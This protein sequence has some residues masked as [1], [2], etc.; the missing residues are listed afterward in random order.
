MAKIYVA[1]S[2]RNEHQQEVVKVLRELRHEVYDFKNPE[3]KTGFQWSEIDKDWQNW[4]T[5]Q[6]REALEHPVAQAGFESDFN[7]MNW[8][9]VC[10]LVLP[11]GRSA[12]TEAGWMA[13][14]GKRV[15]VYSPKREEPE[16]M[17][18]LYDAIFCN[19]VELI[20]YFRLRC[21]ACFAFCD[22][23]LAKPDD[24]PCTDYKDK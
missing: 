21:K 3:G 24:V 22:C 17:Y 8:A 18:K 10:V 11:S 20:C 12:N 5:E 16:L 6:Y 4:T 2:W 9:D 7:A 15:F 1:S 13:G 14:A 23:D 19:M